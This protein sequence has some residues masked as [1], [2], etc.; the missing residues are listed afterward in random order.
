MDEDLPSYD[1]L[2]REQLPS[3]L[4]D[5]EL[6]EEL[7]DV[8]L[9]WSKEKASGCLLPIAADQVRRVRG[10]E[11]R[12]AEQEARRQEQEDADQDEDSTESSGAQTSADTHAASGPAPIHRLF[13]E[14]RALVKAATPFRVPQSEPG[15]WSEVLRG[16]AKVD[17]HFL[18]SQYERGQGLIRLE[19][20]AKHD[21][22]IEVINQNE[23]ECLND[24]FDE[25]E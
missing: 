1:A 15:Q 10:Q 2:I 7:L 22:A 24:V 6:A 21:A 8:I 23:A 9:N 11:A 5:R 13:T 17:Q 18:A 14:L 19:K 3:P 25:D 20:A 12:R 4:P 16:E